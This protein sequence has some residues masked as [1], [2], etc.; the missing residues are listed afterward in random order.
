[1]S[2]QMLSSDVLQ[3]ASEVEQFI[4]YWQ[5]ETLEEALACAH[6]YDVWLNRM[7]R[8]RDEEDFVCQ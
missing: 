3:S 1:M 8:D 5:A 2:L 6:E 7:G 4:N